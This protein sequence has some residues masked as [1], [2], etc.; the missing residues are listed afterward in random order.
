MLLVLCLPLADVEAVSA[1]VSEAKPADPASSP[2]TPR[3]L[4]V[5]PGFHSLPSLVVLNVSVATQILLCN[6]ALCD[7]LYMYFQAAKRFYLAFQ[8]FQFVHPSLLKL[9]FVCRL[10]VK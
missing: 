5:D 2:A 10:A 3:S 6:T 7:R 9:H 4:P 8:C 1:P